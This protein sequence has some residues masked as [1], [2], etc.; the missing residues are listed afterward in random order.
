LTTVRHIF[1]KHFK[2]LIAGLAAFSCLGLSGAALGKSR[3]ISFYSLN[4]GESLTVTYKRDGR[5][6]PSAMR[7]LNYILRDWRANTPTRMDPKVIDLVWELHQ[8]LGSNKPIHLV[9][10]Y[11]TPKTNAMRRRQSRGVAKRSRHMRG[12]AIDMYFPDVPLKLI[13]ETALIKQRGGV[14][15]YPRSRK[16]FVHIDTGNVRHWP[17]MPAA[18]YAA[19]LRRGNK[20][21]RYAVR[22]QR[23]QPTQRIAA[24]A[25]TRLTPPAPRR[26]A[27]V[28]VASAF[29]DLSRI[30]PPLP[31][32]KPILVALA[33]PQGESWMA[34][35]GYRQQPAPRPV[36]ASADAAPVPVSG[37][38]QVVKA[39]LTQST[40]TLLAFVG[41]R[42]ARRKAVTQPIR[43]A[44]RPAKPGTAMVVN[45]Q[46]RR[47][48][49]ASIQR[50]G[51]RAVRPAITTHAVQSPAFQ[52]TLT[53]QH[54]WKSDPATLTA[55]MR[56]PATVGLREFSGQLFANIRPAS[57]ETGPVDMA[58]AATDHEGLGDTVIRRK[59]VISEDNP[60]WIKRVLSD[61]GFIRPA[62][63]KPTR[64]ASI[65]D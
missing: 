59:T 56:E 54:V 26:S 14:G 40:D 28:A 4:T 53:S 7:K 1:G 13:R 47:M 20:F 43:I 25:P 9:S 42:P 38:W 33:A 12:Q 37:G 44:A 31:N 3:T 11:R 58:N 52:I 27:P 55:I 35:S 36:V 10:G 39:R 29:P 15:Y 63:A 5:Y 30:T 32:H 19:L 22:R 50:G 64:S 24:R 21:T 60:G 45:S 57:F 8:N 65:F 6:I 51:N 49:T 46:N 2:T 48:T 41:N 23:S 18:A 16:P 34:P 62:N 61:W 17:R